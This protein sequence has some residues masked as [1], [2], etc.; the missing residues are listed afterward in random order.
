MDET[1]MDATLYL[2]SLIATRL[3]HDLS[4]P[5]NGLSA[6]L[7]DGDVATDIDLARQAARQATDRLILLRAAWGEPGEPMSKADLQRFAAG[8]IRRRTAIDL[9]GIADA[10]CF[11][12]GAARLLLNLM[13]L[14]AESLPRGGVVSL[15]GDQTQ[16]VIMMLDGPNAGWP[17]GLA[18]LMADPAALPA[19]L[20]ALDPRN[21]Q[22]PLT[23]CLA[24]A[25]QH[26]L[27]FLFSG[28]PEHAPP[29]MARLSNR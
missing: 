10:A 25:G 19:T 2:A 1:A 20:R 17:P 3:C 28:T 9:D 23:V 7:G 4:S 12:P 13:L 16:G 24:Q 21:L 22:A 27:S 26:H 29:L 11:P 14:G 15:Q 5:L 6:A 8:A 18:T